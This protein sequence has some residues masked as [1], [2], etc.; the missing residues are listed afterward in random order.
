MLRKLNN[1]QTDTDPVKIANFGS[2]RINIDNKVSNMSKPQGSFFVLGVRIQVWVGSIS[3]VITR[4][5][6]PPH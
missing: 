1:N 2:F 5:M 3:H 4:G 6:V